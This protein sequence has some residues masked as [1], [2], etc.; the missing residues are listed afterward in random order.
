MLAIL[1]NSL[2]LLAILLIPACLV[3]LAIHLFEF[4]IQLQLASRWGWRSV[5]ITGW[6][7]TPIHELSHVIMCFLFR[8]RIDEVRFFDPDPA[9]GRLG[10]VKHSY[11]QGNWFEELGNGFIGIAPFLGGSIALLS[12][13]LMFYPESTLELFRIQASTER[14]SWQLITQIPFE[15]FV[16]FLSSLFTI[17]NLQTVRMWL[18]LYLCLCVAAHMAPSMSDYV[19]A[20]R[21]L[22]LI[23][24]LSLIV[25]ILAMTFTREPLALAK[26][27]VIA[28]MPFMI[29]GGL[30]LALCC[31][32]YIAVA[33]FCR[34]IPA[35][36]PQKRRRC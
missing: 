10:F 36:P 29:L 35:P 22:I 20:L 14:E 25:T 28:V 16:Q 2:S 6:L 7:G 12:L 11:R 5:M 9:S 27:V 17:E 4:S 33:I 31:A 8:H 26:S 19:G 30:S 18:F 34:I 23:T 24:E 3:A 13:S 21:G 1:I 15:A 32:L